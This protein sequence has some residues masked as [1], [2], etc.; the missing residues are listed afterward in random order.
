MPRRRLYQL[1]RTKTTS[2]ARR[3]SRLVTER[4][5]LQGL[6]TTWEEEVLSTHV[7]RAM[8]TLQQQQR[9]L[10][11]LFSQVLQQALKVNDLRMEDIVSKDS[12]SLSQ[13]LLPR[14]DTLIERSLRSALAPKT[15]TKTTAVESARSQE[16]LSR[17]RAAGSDALNAVQGSQSR[18]TRN[19]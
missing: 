10:E 17:F 3:M 18:N 19:Q 6:A 7:G 16:E 12:S 9:R 1:P 11:K 4:H 14:V 13:G 15:R 2:N 8:G 5:N